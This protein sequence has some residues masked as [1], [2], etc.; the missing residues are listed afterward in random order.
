MPLARSTATTGTPARLIASTR[1]RAA[2]SIDDQVCPAD[3][4]GAGRLG[5]TV[6]AARRLCGIPAQPVALAEQQ[7]PHRMAV[8]RQHARR[9]EAVAAIVAGPGRHQHPAWPAEAPRDPLGHRPAGRVHQ[10]D[11][12]DAAGDR[13]PVGAR[14]LVGGEQLDHHGDLT[15]AE[16]APANGSMARTWAGARPKCDQKLGML[17][18]QWACVA[19]APRAAAAI[20]PGSTA[21]ERLPHGARTVGT[22][23]AN[24]MRGSTALVAGKP[25][26]GMR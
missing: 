9:D 24:R 20:P 1:A 14:H 23:S 13:R 16:S 22:E 15:R 10:G 21:K 12:R 6:P 2:P 17:H 4:V 11:P 18:I 25:R 3:G 26:E 19:W 8:L 7:H 5:R